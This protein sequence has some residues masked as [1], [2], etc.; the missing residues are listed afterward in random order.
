MRWRDLENGDL[1]AAGGGRWVRAREN[2]VGPLRQLTVEHATQQLHGWE[3]AQ[4]KHSHH[5]EETPTLRV[6]GGIRHNG[7]DME[8]A[9]IRQGQGM[10]NACRS[11]GEKGA[12]PPKHAGGPGGRC[13]K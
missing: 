10:K 9:G 5:L 12:R 8:A 2:R 13:A 7:Q 11:H 6:H 4:R 3:H 1:H